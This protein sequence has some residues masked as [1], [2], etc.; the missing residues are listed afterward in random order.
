MLRQILVLTLG[1]IKGV[2]IEDKGITLSVHYRQVEDDKVSDIERMMKKVMDRPVSRGLFNI[3][4]GK[5]VYEV[6]PAL[7]WDKGKAIRLLMKRYSKGG[8]HQWITGNLSWR[9]SDGRG[10]FSGGRKIRQ[11]HFGDGWREYY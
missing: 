8:R 9:R 6:R 5:K 7:N 2:F 4:T 1:T 10:W 11:W 3:T